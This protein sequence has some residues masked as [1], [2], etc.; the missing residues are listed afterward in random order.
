M[1]PKDEIDLKQTSS[2]SEPRAPANSGQVRPAQ[3]LK[4][5]IEESLNDEKEVEENGPEAEIDDSVLVSTPED[6]ANKHWTGLELTGNDTN[7]Y[8]EKL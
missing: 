7:N 2:S 6:V 4:Q 3:Y 1:S 8:F 5:L